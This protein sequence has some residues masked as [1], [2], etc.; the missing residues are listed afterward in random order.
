[1]KNTIIAYHLQ[2]S[3]VTMIRLD[4]VVFMLFKVLLK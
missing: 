3:L 4:F 2:L 1:M